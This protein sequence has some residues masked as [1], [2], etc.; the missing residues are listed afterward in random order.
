[1]CVQGS[2]ATTRS[3]RLAR[4]D[5]ADAQ[6]GSLLAVL[7]QGAKLAI[8]AVGG[9]GRQEICPGSDLDLLFIHE[10]M[11]TSQLKTIVDGV[12]FPLWDA[13]Q[14][15]DHSVRTVEQTLALAKADVKVAL[16]LL[17]VRHVA[18]DVSV[19]IE[20]ASDG[21]R[22]WRG[23]S[24]H[25]L[26]KL[27]SMQL[28]R[29]KRSGELAYFIE[30]DLKEARGGLRDITVL[31][32]IAASWVA[33][34]P[35]A[36]IDE[37]NEFLLDVR[38]ALHV[39][40]GR[41]KNQLLLQE[42]DQV[43]NIL[44][45]VDADDL[46]R[47]V[48]EAGRAVDYANELTWRRVDQGNQESK[49]NRYGRRRPAVSTRVAQDLVLFEGEVALE[50]AANVEGDEFLTLRAGATAAQLENPISPI[51]CMRL[52]GSAPVLATPW[53]GRARD[54]FISL[55]GAGESSLV[56]W[57]ALDQAGLIIRLIPEWQAVRNLPQR[58]VLHRHTVDRHLLETVIQAKGLLRTVRRP[59][60]LLVAALFHDIGK[61]QVG[62][63][64]EVGAKLMQIIAM[65]MGFSRADAAVLESL[66]LHH[67]LLP[68]TATRRDLDDPQTISNV[69]EK[70]DEQVASL[71]LLHALT[72]ADGL[73]TSGTAWSPWKAKLVEQLVER[74]KSTVAGFPLPQ[75]PQLDDE[76]VLMAA[77][78][79]LDVRV[80]PDEGHY[81]ILVVAPDS[82][83]LLAK[84]SGVLSLA[85]LD[86]KAAKTLT[87][88]TS[89]VMRWQVTLA[90]YG[91]IP[92]A[93][94]ILDSLR[95]SLTGE[96]EVTRRLRERARDHA[97]PSRMPT[98]PPVV[99]VLQDQAS[100]AT[101]LEIRSH[102]RPGLLHDVAMAVT[103]AGIDVHA[104][105]VSTLGAEA[106]DVFYVTELGGGPLS[107]AEG[108]RVAALVEFELC[109]V[110]QD[111][112][113]AG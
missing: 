71:D 1:M 57:E 75:E 113:P 30:P 20:L 82:P 104:A 112:S 67:L 31:R 96:F 27:R 32:A 76:L 8:F 18:G 25:M 62:D 64:S 43:A 47:L 83:G 22:T 84:V 99:A 35:H 13:G 89:A 3:D 72:I 45:L 16:G 85:K 19:G 69:L 14:E 56:V 26:P 81:E 90:P 68:D 79:T 40:T 110:A 94:A 98:S 107:L 74:I 53:S 48:A 28:D 17:D 63:H 59:D 41:K 101:V 9:Y 70:L 102:D 106:C 5:A 2:A 105:I 108:E 11:A 6:V 93:P 87:R 80:K 58:N 42:Q 60:L 55:I 23:N 100:H 10:G 78:S 50:F 73:A 92:E 29:I 15:I 24:G 91:Q 44:G 51:T 86:V 39:V 46:L 66:V 38:E 34:L 103:S 95:R 21:L 7:R 61:G 54:L 37:S 65:R 49:R 111:L 97:R 88:N 33:D 52:A 12:L 36:K 77:S 109:K 4:S